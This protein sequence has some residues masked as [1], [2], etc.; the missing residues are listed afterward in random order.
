MEFFLQNIQI[1]TILFHNLNQFQ[2]QFLFCRCRI[3]CSRSSFH[4]SSE[5]SWAHV[6]IFDVGRVKLA[7][8]DIIWKLKHK[9]VVNIDF[10]PF[11]HE[12]R[13]ASVISNDSSRICSSTYLFSS[14]WIQNDVIR[15]WAWCIPNFTFN[16]CIYWW[17]NN[18][19]FRCN[20]W[21]IECLW[22]ERPQLAHI[23]Y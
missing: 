13:R 16:F 21:C 9:I 10:F 23:F 15:L 22:M 7:I 20:S 6:G 8:A 2:I 12:S 3:R 1:Q 5:S 19:C 17:N 14:G 4:F 11:F 18:S